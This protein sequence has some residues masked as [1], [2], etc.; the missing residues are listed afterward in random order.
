MSIS[1]IDLK[2][3][4]K[5][6]GC[7]SECREVWMTTSTKGKEKLKMEEHSNTLHT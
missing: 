5:N 2:G 3:M 1:G 6:C 4:K 7:D